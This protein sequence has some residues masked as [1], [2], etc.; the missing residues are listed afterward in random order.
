MAKINTLKLYLKQVLFILSLYNYHEI[1]R[2][3]TKDRAIF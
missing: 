1:H 2:K 3:I